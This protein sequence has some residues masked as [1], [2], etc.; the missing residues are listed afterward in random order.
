MTNIHKEITIDNRI[1]LKG[2]R[3]DTKEEDLENIFKT[4]GAI[5]ETKIIRDNFDGRSKGY[6]S[7]P[8]TVNKL[9][10]TFYVMFN[11]FK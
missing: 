3:P 2:L 4:Y 10:K 5:V 9:L 1:F 7:S 11:R 6:G 8:S